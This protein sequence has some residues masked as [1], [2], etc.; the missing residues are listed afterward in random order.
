MLAYKDPQIRHDPHSYIAVPACRPPQGE[1]PDVGSTV[2]LL[3]DAVFWYN[4]G[5]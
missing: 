5:G 2:V 3:R 1:T 4:A